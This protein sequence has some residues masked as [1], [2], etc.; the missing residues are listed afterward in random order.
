MA[1]KNVQTMEGTPVILTGSTWAKI[2]AIAVG[3]IAA[4]WTAHYQM[5]TS[6]RSEMLALDDKWQTRMEAVSRE[7]R[8]D[9]R[10]VRNGI[11]PDWFREMVMTNTKKIDKMEEEFTR[12]F[13]RKDELLPLLKAYWDRKEEKRE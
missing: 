6:L 12:D 2:I 8:G 7:I 9:I 4:L 10:E 11:P 5:A 13:I 1:D 3:T